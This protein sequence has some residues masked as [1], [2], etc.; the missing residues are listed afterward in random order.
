M[1][2]H[3][4]IY[5]DPIHGKDWTE[6]SRD[7]IRIFVIETICLKQITMVAFPLLKMKISALIFCLTFKKLENTYEPLMWWT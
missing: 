6:A 1:C 2:S 7:V 5:V 4:A 3:L